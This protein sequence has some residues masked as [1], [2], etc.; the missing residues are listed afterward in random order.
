MGELRER[1]RLALPLLAGL[2]GMIVPIAIY[3]PINAGH[4]SAHGWGTAMS[5][6]T[7][8]ALGVLALVGRR[9]PDRVRTYLL[10]VLRR[11]RPG[12][13]RGHRVRLQRPHSRGGAADRAGAPRRGSSCGR[14]GSA[15]APAYALL[16]V[17]AWV[18]IFKSGVD[19]VLVGLV[20]GLL[21]FARPATRVTWSRPP[22][23][24][25]CSASSRRRSWPAPRATGSG[26]RSRPTTGCSSCYHPLTSYVIVPLFALAN[27]GMVISGSFLARAYTSPI[28]LGIL[29]GYVVGKPLGTGGAAWLVTRVSR[30]R[31]RPP[32]GWAAVAGA[33][34]IARHRLHRVAADRLARLPRRAARGGQG[35]G[36][37]GGARRVCATWT[38]FRLVARLPKPLQIRALFGTSQ[39]S[40]T[41]PC[42][43]TPSATT[44]AARRSRRSRGRVRRLRVPVLRPGRAG[45]SR[46]AGRLRRRSLRLAAPAAQRRAPARPA[47]CRGSRGGG[48]ASAFWE[49]HDLLLGHQGA[50]RP[51]DLVGYAATSASTSRGSPTT[52]SSTPARP[53]WPRTST[54]PT[55]AGCRARPTFFIN[56]M[57]APRR[58]R[59]RARSRPRSGRPGPGPRSRRDRAEAGPAPAHRHHAAAALPRLPRPDQRADGVGPGHPADRGRGAVPGVRA[60]PLLARR[61]AGLARPA[62]PAGHRVAGR[63]LGGRCREPP[64]PA[65]GGR[66]AGRSLQR[67]PGGQRG[68]DARAVAAVRPAGRGRHA[69]RIRQLGAQRHGPEHGPAVRGVHRQRHVPGAVPA[70]RGS[71]A[72]RCRAAAGRA[73]YPLRVLDGRGQLRRVA[74]VG[75]P[76]F[77]A[78]SGPRGAPARAFARS[79]RASPSCAGARPSR[80]PT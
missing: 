6:D 71:R 62:L 63:G 44:C 14:R 50:L 42:R 5:T 8:F 21:T 57:P 26:P 37:L 24:S 77:P 16:G 66:V 55:S 54:P 48:Q 3:L 46:A 60:D 64:P 39:S 79:S 52:S 68:P 28:T 41:W 56:G 19:P 35:R 20:I 40:S 22:T 29:V 59:H 18:A 78:A 1:R 17:A 7:A 67:R 13:H 70:R 47:R 74:A 49:M 73:R 76:D 43:S 45:G 9:L 2:G 10:T 15:T 72:G 12:R 33:G 32:V 69:E 25:G 61:R 53:T 30:G 75:I 58:L 36:A 27:T 34:A 4:P 11:R 38:V 80:A 23:C 65:A 51:P 31:I